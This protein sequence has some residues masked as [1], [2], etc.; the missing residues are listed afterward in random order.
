[1]PSPQFLAGQQ[2]SAA[3]LQQ[4]GDSD[5]TWIPTLEGQTTN[6]DLGGSP[7]Q[8]SMVHLN[9]EE[10]DLWFALQFGSSSDPGEGAYQVPL[11]AAYPIMAGFYDT[12]FGQG[13]ILEASPV[14]VVTTW[15]SIDVGGQFLYFRNQADATLITHANPQSW[16]DGDWLL[17][18]ATY[19]TD[20]GV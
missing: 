19:L 20:F 16:D 1:M 2:L 4:L 17:G 18:H 9:G 3:Q 10:V 15:V 6:P 12:G 11:P 13:R 8:W 5:S 7:V 14:A